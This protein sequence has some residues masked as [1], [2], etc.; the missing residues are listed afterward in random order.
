VVAIVRATDVF[1]AF[2]VRFAAKLRFTAAFFDFPRNV[3]VTFRSRVEL[4]GSALAAPAVVGLFL[5]RPRPTRGRVNCRSF[6][7]PASPGIRP[8]AN[9]SPL[10]A[11]SASESVP[12]LAVLGR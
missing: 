8:L 10:R 5:F 1:G 12:G 2:F 3:F 9:L 11:A 6:L 7:T 4:G